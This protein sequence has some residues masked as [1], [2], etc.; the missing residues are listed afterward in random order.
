MET[1]TS[2]TCARI[3]FHLVRTSPIHLYFAKSPNLRAGVAR[4][5][6]FRAPARMRSKSFFNPP[7][8]LSPSPSLTTQKQKKQKKTVPIQQQQQQQQR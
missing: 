2:F 4:G 7:I 8:L 3:G 6:R 5:T 1:G